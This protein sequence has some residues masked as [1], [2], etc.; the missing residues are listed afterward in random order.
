MFNFNELGLSTGEKVL[1]NLFFLMRGCLRSCFREVVP[2]V[3]ARLEENLLDLSLQLLE[4][5]RAVLLLCSSR[6]SILSY[7]G[8]FG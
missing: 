2:K 6:H 7:P 8:S 3:L 4:A 1:S 5:F